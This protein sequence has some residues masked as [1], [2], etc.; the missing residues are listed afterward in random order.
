MEDR[1]DESPW[2]AEVERAA[3]LQAGEGQRPEAA[4]LEAGGAGG[5]AAGGWAPRSVVAGL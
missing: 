5:A 3:S 1:E 2:T 4:V